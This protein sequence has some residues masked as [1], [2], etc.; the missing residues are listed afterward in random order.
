MAIKRM[1]ADQKQTKL[2]SLIQYNNMYHF[3][4]LE[5]MAL[6]ADIRSSAKE[7]VEFL[8]V[9]NFIK[10]EKIGISN[11][12]F[13]KPENQKLNLM[14]LE[15]ELQL[16]KREKERLE[17]ELG[18]MKDLV[19]DET[20]IKKSIELGELQAEAEKKRTELNKFVTETDYL[21]VLSKVNEYKESLNLMTDNI[22]SVIAF[23]KDK[24]RET[25]EIHKAFGIPED[26]DF[27]E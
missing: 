13:K 11:I 26:F 18:N 4:E 19:K 5:K 24:G 10:Q 12:Y 9:E 7:I 20:N 21:Q 15:E 14:K 17:S 8:V 16:I 3:N 23:L 27:F 25:G 1:S 6:K 22:F 2:L